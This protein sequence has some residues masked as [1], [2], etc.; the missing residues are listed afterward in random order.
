[1]KLWIFAIL[2]LPPGVVLMAI[3]IAEIVSGYVPWLAAQIGHAPTWLSVAAI[4]LGA[5]SASLTLSVM[6]LRQRVRNLVAL[7]RT[8]AQGS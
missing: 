5:L 1:M 6:Y 3:G 8:N 2:Y 4:V 7:R